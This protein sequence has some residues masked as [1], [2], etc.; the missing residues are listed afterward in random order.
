MQVGLYVGANSTVRRFGSRR[1]RR[2]AVSVPALEIPVQLGQP[3]QVHLAPPLK[4]GLFD[5]LHAVPAFDEDLVAG[6]EIPGEVAIQNILDPRAMVEEAEEGSA[7]RLG[8]DRVARDHDIEPTLLIRETVALADPL[9]HDR[10]AVAEVDEEP[11]DAFLVQG[12]E[13][14]VAVVALKQLDHRVE[15]S[16]VVDESDFEQHSAPGHPYRARLAVA[17]S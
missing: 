15:R 7:V 2:R 10:R 5:P 3:D 12:E 17:C 1:Q 16:L 9:I 8:A 14:V 13:D 6:V 4:T 11:P